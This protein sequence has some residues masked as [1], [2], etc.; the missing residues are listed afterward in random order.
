MEEQWRD[1]VARGHDVQLHLH[2]NWLP[3]M[4]PTVKDGR[5][6]WDMERTRASD[7]PGDLAEAIGRCKTA[8]EE[9]IGPISPDYEVVAY[10]AGTYEAQPFDRLYDALLANDIWCDSSVLPGD[11]RSDRHYEY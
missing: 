3:E 9:A 1:A 5:W 4:E 7:Y 10:R 11:R 8:L 2:P 6:Q